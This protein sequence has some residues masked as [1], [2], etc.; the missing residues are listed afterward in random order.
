MAACCRETTRASPT[1][2]LATQN[3][4]GRFPVIPINC[5]LSSV[6]LVIVSVACRTTEP[7]GVNETWKPPVFAGGQHPAERR[8]IEPRTEDAA[9]AISTSSPVGFVNVNERVRVSPVCTT[10]KER[11]FGRISSAGPGSGSG[12]GG[13]KP[14]RPFPTSPSSCGLSGA[15]LVTVQERTLETAQQ[16][17]P[18]RGAQPCLGQGVAAKPAPA[19]TRPA[20]PR[21]EIAALTWIGA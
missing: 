2:P 18:R 4:P 20:P 10:P 5:G 17:A 7:N 21:Y 3:P 19:Q 6:E 14:P 13:G 16:T 15:V 1:A 11:V 12:S 9:N 8:P